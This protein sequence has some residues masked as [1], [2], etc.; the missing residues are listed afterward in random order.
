V[1]NS[2]ELAARFPLTRFMG[3]FGS[4]FGDWSYS[5]SLLRTALG[6]GEVV[7]SLWYARPSVQ[8]FALGGLESFGQAFSR[9]TS[10]RYRTMPVYQ[11]LLG[12]PTLRLFYPPRMGSLSAQPLTGGVTLT[13]SPWSAR[14][15][16]GYHVYRRLAGTSGPA[17]RLTP[18]PIAVET[19]FDTSAAPRSTYEWRVVAVV[20]ETTGSG[21]FWNHSLG[22]RASATTLEAPDAGSLDAGPPDAG[23]PDAGTED[24]GTADAGSQDAG[25]TDGGSIDGGNAGSDGGASDAGNTSDAGLDPA[26]GGALPPPL[27]LEPVVGCGCSTDGSLWLLVLGAWPLRR[28]RGR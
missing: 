5:N 18:S 2:A 17:V 26:D 28:R 25:Q 14:D 10:F 16:V 3:L 19:W 8:L 6:S 15:L 9:D 13:W 22:A 11:A 20:R 23:P 27:P 12:D 1:T 4:Y 7:A 21:T 24:A